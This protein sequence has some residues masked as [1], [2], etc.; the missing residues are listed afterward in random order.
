MKIFNFFNKKSDDS[1][2]KDPDKN[3]QNTKPPQ[4]SSLKLKFEEKITGE[5]DSLNNYI[6]DFKFDG[7]IFSNYDEYLKI[8]NFLMSKNNQIQ[9]KFYQNELDFF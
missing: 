7:M 5:I 4:P 3:N 6:K 9:N 8:Q 1:G 2:G